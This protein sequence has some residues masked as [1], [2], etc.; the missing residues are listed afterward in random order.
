MKMF[1]GSSLKGKSSKVKNSDSR[2]EVE[3]EANDPYATKVIDMNTW[4]VKDGKNAP[5]DLYST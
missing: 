1:K 4:C 3:H 2:L 5:F